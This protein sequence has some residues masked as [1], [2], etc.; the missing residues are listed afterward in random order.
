MPAEQAIQLATHWA[1]N[2]SMRRARGADGSTARRLRDATM[3]MVSADQLS[4]G[5]VLPRPT[6]DQASLMHGLG[7]DQRRGEAA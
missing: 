6:I 2:V 4:D 1:E 7:G 5:M 3:G